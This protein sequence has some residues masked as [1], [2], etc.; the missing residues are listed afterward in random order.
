[1]LKRRFSSIQAKI[2]PSFMGFGW[3]GTG[4]ALLHWSGV[5]LISGMENTYVKFFSL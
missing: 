2:L 4:A 3:R 5:F 1:M